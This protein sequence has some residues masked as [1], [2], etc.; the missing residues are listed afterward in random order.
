[1]VIITQQKLEKCNNPIQSLSSN[2]S[3]RS[4]TI[5]CQQND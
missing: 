1:M 3:H 5:N 2:Y 4:K